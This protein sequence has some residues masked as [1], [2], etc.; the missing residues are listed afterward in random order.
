MASVAMGHVS[1]GQLLNLA[2][3]DS[4]ALPFKP[5][6]ATPERPCERVLCSPQVA[7]LDGP[8]FSG[9]VLTARLNRR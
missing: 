8:A 9:G 7:R 5:G 3:L 6:N 2:Q 1:W 4:L